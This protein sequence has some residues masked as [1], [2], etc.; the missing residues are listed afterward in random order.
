MNV[1]TLIAGSRAR[2]A[3]LSLATAA[4]AVP[5]AITPAIAASAG[6]AAATPAMTGWRAFRLPLPAGAFLSSFA[7]AAISCYSTR[8]C[9]GGATYANIRG[10]QA[11]LLR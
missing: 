10:H 9:S 7:P 1:R 8:V 11:A 6:P 3:L 5:L 2:T 4:L